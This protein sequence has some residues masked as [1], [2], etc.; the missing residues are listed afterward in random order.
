MAINARAKGANGEREVI[1]MLQEVIDEVATSVSEEY[2]CSFEFP[3][4]IRNTLQSAQGGE[5]IH[6]LPWYAVEVKRCEKQDIGRWW[7]QTTRQSEA[8][9]SADSFSTLRLELSAASRLVSDAELRAGGGV[10]G[11]GRGVVRRVDLT[12][13]VAKPQKVPVLT[14][15]ANNQPWRVVIWGSLGTLDGKAIR[16]PVDIAWPAFAL[17]LKIDLRVRLKAEFDRLFPRQ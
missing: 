14:Y 7:L 6:G 5:D 11:S 9:N 15:R 1:N 8:K 10:A 13:V 2:G 17:W 3:R 4:L 12:G 16:C